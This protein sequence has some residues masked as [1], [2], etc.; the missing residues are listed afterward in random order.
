VLVLTAADPFGDR[1]RGVAVQAGQQQ[2][3]LLAAQPREQVGSAHTRP[4]GV[5]EI[6]QRAVAGGVTEGVVQSFEVVEI[7]HQQRRRFS[8]RGGRRHGRPRPLDELATPVGT[9]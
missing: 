2:R 7:H 5:R 1:H 8:A 6:N 9:R 4:R 3:E